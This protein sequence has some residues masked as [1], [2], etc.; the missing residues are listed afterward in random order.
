MGYYYNIWYNLKRIY[1]GIFVS[2][3]NRG[4]FESEINIEKRIVR[5]Y[6]KSLDKINQMDDDRDGEVTSCCGWEIINYI[7]AGVPYLHSWVSTWLSWW[8]YRYENGSQKHTI[9][10]D[11]Y[12]V[13]KKTFQLTMNNHEIFQTKI[14]CKIESI[15][16]DQSKL[17]LSIR[18]QSCN[19]IV[20]F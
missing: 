19:F 17:F 15:K 2:G 1:L 16:I 7:I 5:I 20:S 11:P 13:I 18:K 4:H 6:S 3:Y 12:R 14:L 9:T 10:S 8:K